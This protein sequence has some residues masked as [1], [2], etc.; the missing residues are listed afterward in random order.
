LGGFLGELP[1]SSADI[2]PL[3]G[4]PATLRSLAN[5]LDGP[6][7]GDLEFAWQAC[8]QLQ[9][10]QSATSCDGQWFD[11]FR[12]K[13]ERNPKPEDIDQVRQVMFEAAR[14][15]R[16]LAWRLEEAQRKLEW[17]RRRIDA[18]EVPSDLLLDPD[19]EAQLRSIGSQADSVHEDASTFVADAAN[20]LGAL[21]H[22]TLY[23]EPPTLADRITGGIGDLAGDVVGGGRWYWDNVGS[24]LWLGFGESSWQ[25][26]TS[27]YDF[28]KSYAS[29]IWG[30]VVAN[31]LVQK[32]WAPA[33][34]TLGDVR[35]AAVGAWDL[36]S[37]LAVYLGRDVWW[38][39]LRGGDWSAAEANGGPY[40]ELGKA[41]VD[42]ETLRTNP[43]RWVGHLMPDALLGLGTG[44]I[45]AVA[46]RTAT[47]GARSPRLL[48]L[49]ESLHKVDGT[50]NV[51]APIIGRVAPALGI[52]HIP[53]LGDWVRD[54]LDLGH[55]PDPATAHPPD[56]VARDHH[57]DGG[58]PNPTRDETSSPR[59]TTGD[60]HP[61][62]ADDHG[63]PSS[64]SPDPDSH[65]TTPPADRPSP[66]D[67]TSPDPA[68]GRHPSPDPGDQT[69]GH[70]TT[71]GDRVPGDSGSPGDR[72]PGDPGSPGD[73]TP[74]TPGS[75]GDRVP[76]DPGTPGDTVPG[77]G[78]PDGTGT[79]APGRSGTS[80]PSP[81]GTPT[82]HETPLPADPVSHDPV[83][84]RPHDPH[85]SRHM[86]QVARS[87]GGVTDAG[88]HHG[89]TG[90]THPS[91]PGRTHHPDADPGTAAHPGRPTPSHD[92]HDRHGTGLSA[93]DV[94]RLGDPATRAR[95]VHSTPI[96]VEADEAAGAVVAANNLQ[97]TSA[98][99]QH[100]TRR[101]SPVQRPRASN[102]D[103]DPPTEPHERTGPTDPPP[104]STSPDDEAS[105]ASHDD[106]GSGDGTSRFD[107]LLNERTSRRGGDDG[108][109]GGS[110]D[111]P[112]R[113]DDLLN[114][115]ITP[116]GKDRV[117]DEP[118]EEGEAGHPD[119][120]VEAGPEDVA[121]ADEDH[122]REREWWEQPGALTGDADTS[123]GANVD[124]DATDVPDGDGSHERWSRLLD[125]DGHS[126]R[127]AT[128]GADV[129][130]DATDVPDGDGS[131]ER[132]SR[133]LDEDGHSD[134]PDVEGD[135]DGDP[136][137]AVP[138]KGGGD[139]HSDSGG[140]AHEHDVAEPPRRAGDV[141]HPRAGRSSHNGPGRAAPP[142]GR[143][144]GGGDE[145]RLD[146]DDYDDLGVVDHGVYARL[147]RE[148]PAGWNELFRRAP[149][150]VDR[151]TAA[152]IDHQRSITGQDRDVLRA[153]LR[154]M[155]PD[156]AARA[157]PSDLVDDL[158][159][160]RGADEGG[161]DHDLRAAL[162]SAD[163]IREARQRYLHPLPASTPQGRADDLPPQDLLQLVTHYSSLS[164]EDNRRVQEWILDSLDGRQTLSPEELWER[165]SFL[166]GMD[167]R[168]WGD[169]VDHRNYGRLQDLLHGPCRRAT[170]TDRTQPQD[171]DVVR[172][173]SP[174]VAE[175]GQAP[176]VHDRPRDELPLEPEFQPDAVRPRPANDDAGRTEGGD[177][178][179]ESDDDG[180]GGARS[181][182]DRPTPGHDSDSRG[183]GPDQDPAPPAP[184]R[185]QT[186]PST[187]DADG[188][189]PTHPGRTDGAG[190]SPLETF[191]DRFVDHPADP[192]E[193]L[194]KEGMSWPPRDGDGLYEVPDP[195][196][197]LVKVPRELGPMPPLPASSRGPLVP[198]IEGLEDSLSGDP[199]LDRLRDVNL[200]GG[201]DNCIKTAV[202][203]DMRLAGRGHYIANPRHLNL[204]GQSSGVH[205]FDPDDDRMVSPYLERLYGT[206]FRQMRVLPDVAKSL[207]HDGA[208]GIVNVVRRGR[209]GD[210]TSHALNA[211]RR[212]GQVHFVDG[213]VPGGADVTAEV[214]SA[215]QKGN[216]LR[217]DLLRTDDLHA[218]PDFTIPR[219]GGDGIDAGPSDTV[220]NPGGP[221]STGSVPEGDGH[222]R[223]DDDLRPARRAAEEPV[224]STDAAGDGGSDVGG[225]RPPADSPDDPGDEFSDGAGAH[226]DD[227]GA[228]SGAD[229]DPTA[230]ERSPGDFQR[231][232]LSLPDDL[233]SL[234][235]DEVVDLLRRSPSDWY[236]LTDHTRRRLF[237][238]LFE[239]ADGFGD[240]DL[241]LFG[242]RWSRL[243]PEDF[244][245]ALPL[246]LE[247]DRLGELGSAL[248]RG[249][250][251][252]I[253][254]NDLRSA[255]SLDGYRPGRSAPAHPPLVDSSGQRLSYD[256]LTA[257]YRDFPEL[258][259]TLP[260]GARGYAE[261]IA[262]RSADCD[263]PRDELEAATNRLR[264]LGGEP[265]RPE[266]TAERARQRA[267]A[268]DALRRLNAAT[269][270]YC[271]SI[272]AGED[273]LRDL[274][275]VSDI[276][277][278]N[279]R[280]AL[281]RAHHWRGDEGQVWDRV[282]ASNLPADLD[283]IPHDRFVAFV[284]GRDLDL[285]SD[286]D[287]AHLASEVGMRLEMGELEPADMDVLRPVFGRLGPLPTREDLVRSMVGFGELRPDT[288][289]ELHRYIRSAYPDPID[290]PGTHD[291]D[292][293]PDEHPD[294]RPDD[295]GS[296]D[297]GEEH[298]GPRTAGT[299]DPPA[300]RDVSDP[301]PGA[302]ALPPDPRP[303]P[304]SVT[305]GGREAHYVGRLSNGDRL[306]DEE[307]GGWLASLPHQLSDTQLWRL[308]DQL[309][310]YLDRFDDEAFDFLERKFR[311]AGPQRV[312]QVVDTLPHPEYSAIA[313]MVDYLDD[314]PLLTRDEL[315]DLHQ[316]CRDLGRRRALGLTDDSRNPRAGDSD[317]GPDGSGDDG[318]GDHRPGPDDGT[319]PRD[320][321]D[322]GGINPV[323]GGGA[324]VDAPAERRHV[325]DGGASS[326]PRRR[327][328]E[329]PPGHRDPESEQRAEGRRPSGRRRSVVR[330]RRVAA[331][332]PRSDGSSGRLG[333]VRNA[334]GEGPGRHGDAVG[335]DGR[336]G[337][338][339][340][341][342]TR[343]VAGTAGRPLGTTPGSPPGR[344]GHGGSDGGE[345]PPRSARPG[346]ADGD[347][348]DDDRRGDA[349][350]S[351]DPGRSEPSAEPATSGVGRERPIIPEG[352]REPHDP[353]WKGGPAGIGRGRPFAAP[354]RRTPG[355]RHSPG[356]RPA[357][358]ASPGARSP[359]EAPGD[360][361]TS[362]GGPGSL[363]GARSRGTTPSEGVGIG[364]PLL[365]PGGSQRPGAP[366]Y[367]GP[368]D[369]GSTGRASAGR[370]DEPGPPHGRSDGVPPATRAEHVRPEDQSGRR[371]RPDPDSDHLPPA[372]RSGPRQF[373]EPAAGDAYGR[374]VWGD[375]VESASPAQR[376]AAITWRNDGQAVNRYLRTGEHGNDHLD[377]T[378]RH[379]DALLDEHPTPEDLR[380]TSSIE[381]ADM[382][383]ARGPFKLAA[384][385]RRVGETLH[386]PDYRSTVPWEPVMFDQNRDGILHLLVPEGTPAVY[387]GPVQP[388]DP[389]A[390]LLLGR[391]LDVEIVRVNRHDGRFHVY[392][393][394]VPR[395]GD[396]SPSHDDLGA[397]DRT[398]S[399]GDDDLGP[400]DDRGAG[401]PA[402]PGPAGPDDAGHGAE[403]DLPAEHRQADGRGGPAPDGDVDRPPADL[404]PT[405]RRL[406]REEGER[407]AREVWGSVADEAE[408]RL[409]AILRDWPTYAPHVNAYL[410]DLRIVRFP[411]FDTLANRFERAARLK[412]TP[413]AIHVT[414]TIEA[415]DTFGGAQSPGELVAGTRRRLVGF[416]PVVPWEADAGDLH[417]DVPA[418]TPVAY[419]GGRL[420]L[421]QG[422]EVDIHEVRVVAGRRHLHGRVVP[423]DD[424][425]PGDA[426]DGAELPDAG[427]HDGDG[428]GA[429]GEP[430]RAHGNGRV[431]RIPPFDRARVVRSPA[432]AGSRRPTGDG[433]PQRSRR[434]GTPANRDDRHGGAHPPRRDNRPGRSPADDRPGRGPRRL[435]DGTVGRRHPSEPVDAAVSRSSDP[436]GAHRPHDVAA[437]RR[438]QAHADITAGADGGRLVDPRN[439][440]AGQPPGEPRPRPV[441]DGPDSQP[442]STAEGRAPV[443]GD[444]SSGPHPVGPVDVPGSAGDPADRGP[445]LVELLRTRAEQINHDAELAG[446]RPPTVASV[447]YDHVT[448]DLHYGVNNSTRQSDEGLSTHHGPPMILHP[449][450]VDRL[451]A[452]SLEAWPPG[453][454]AEVHA[455]NTAMY[456]A[457][458]PEH[459]E[460][461]PPRPVTLDRFSYA[462]VKT[463]TG[464]V[465][466]SCRNCQAILDG[467]EEIL[468]PGQLGERI[469]RAHAR[470]GS[471]SSLRSAGPDAATRVADGERL[472]WPSGPRPRRTARPAARAAGGP[473]GRAAPSAAPPSVASDSTPLAPEIGPDEPI[474]AGG[475]DEPGDRGEH[476]SPDPGARDREGPGDD[477]GGGDGDGG[478][479]SGS[480]G[481]GTDGGDGDDHGDGT[482]P[483]GPGDPADGGP[484]PGG[485]DIP[486]ALHAGQQVDPEAYGRW[487][488]TLPD[489]PGPTQLAALLHHLPSRVEMLE[490]EVVRRIRDIGGTVERRRLHAMA[491]AVR[492]RGAF[493][494]RPDAS[495]LG[496]GRWGTGPRRPT[497]VLPEDFE[498]RTPAETLEHL[499][500]LDFDQVPADDLL[501]I[502]RKW[503]GWRDEGLT[504]HFAEVG[505]LDRLVHARNRLPVE[506][507]GTEA[508]F[509]NVLEGRWP[510]RTLGIQPTT[511]VEDVV[512]GAAELRAIPTDDRNVPYELRTPT[513]AERA[514]ILPHDIPP[515]PLNEMSDGERARFL[516]EVA[517]SYRRMPGELREHVLNH[518]RKVSVPL[519]ERGRDHSHSVLARDWAYVIPEDVALR[520]TQVENVTEALGDSGL[521]DEG[522]L[523]HFRKA[524]KARRR[525]MARVRQGVQAAQRRPL[526]DDGSVIGDGDGGDASDGDGDDGGD[527]GDGDGNGG[528]DGD[529][530]TGTAGDPARPGAPVRPGDTGG[531]AR[532]DER[533]GDGDT[534]PRSDAPEPSAPES[535]RDPLP[536][537]PSRP[538]VVELSYR[539]SPR[540]FA[541]YLCDDG[542]LWDDIDVDELRRLWP[543]LVRYQDAFGPGDVAVL[544]ERWAR[545]DGE[546][547]ATLPDEVIDDPATMGALGAA[548]P[549]AEE[550]RV[551]VRIHRAATAELAKAE[552]LIVRTLPPDS[553]PDARQAIV[554]EAREQARAYAERLT[555]A[556]TECIRQR[557]EL[558]RLLG[559]RP[560]DL[561]TPEGQ[562]HRLRVE[563]EMDAVLEALDDAHTAYR[564]ADAELADDTRGRRPPGLTALRDDLDRVSHDLF[565][566]TAQ[567][568]D[569]ETLSAHDLVRYLREL[570]ARRRRLTTRVFE[571]LR[572]RL[573]SVPDPGRRIANGLVDHGVPPGERA[574][575][576]AALSEL[577]PDADRAA[578][579]LGSQIR[580][581][582]YL[583]GPFDPF[584]TGRQGGL[585]PARY[586]RGGLRVADEL[587]WRIG[588]RRVN[589]GRDDQAWRENLQDV[590]GLLWENWGSLGESELERL[591]E[592]FATCRRE[593]ICTREE[594]DE[595]LE[596]SRPHSAVV[597]THLGLR[598]TFRERQ[599]A[600]RDGVQRLFPVE[601]AFHRML[602]EAFDQDVAEILWDIQPNRGM[603][604]RTLVYRYSRLSPGQRE[605]LLRAVARGL[606]HEASNELIC[607]RLRRGLRAVDREQLEGT[608]P[609]LSASEQLT[610]FRLGIPTA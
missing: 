495:W 365:R 387:F 540:D 219:R 312:Q 404:P 481:D 143:P 125:E 130:G 37:G 369:D 590:V 505:D 386:M 451:P 574:A 160:G 210:V 509:R 226:H 496:D 570:Q 482:P 46:S 262:A 272:L 408:P 206:R 54:K 9:T 483:A 473:G 309:P 328:N 258:V 596:A 127:P 450:L 25:M 528:D 479:G 145:P 277:R 357:E 247:V 286:S 439:D 433:A 217:I 236:E 117:P 85:G 222:G 164:P 486:E 449:E 78:Q 79:G 91:H 89:R 423:P 61:D 601:N 443:D 522:E 199:L 198:P 380:V 597:R 44:S 189:G 399:D 133:L 371:Q 478:T 507:Q 235:H 31:G 394:V 173:P 321:P 491:R 579:V 358:D 11:Q 572:D 41:L 508:E 129:D 178:G 158:I 151:F 581:P 379:L 205:S 211:V 139:D 83:S 349:D 441:G 474:L 347:G 137:G 586:Q 106:T 580:A 510:G 270:E 75:P 194:G 362:S 297:A 415:T 587:R 221:E 557:A 366:H 393:R 257:V 396:V 96:P 243:T 49:A 291:T 21:S 284:R 207:P 335:D 90:G 65:T 196:D 541:R 100:A 180:L 368:G 476:D 42:Y 426:G 402:R 60:S 97:V 120:P 66:G 351:G 99:L 345:I 494:Q 240:D 103:A 575:A 360:R 150:T 146:P 550:I 95:E 417:L 154:S 281:S 168:L 15:L 81:D 553:D 516:R 72:V 227:A 367:R 438:A 104:R 477:G 264:E 484:D 444:G 307:F 159:D 324:E 216:L 610:L 306:T 64:T 577:F 385:R 177:R 166:R 213:Q 185:S 488:R 22:K 230:R 314:P 305:V 176:G 458:I 118:A 468:N 165:R 250:D 255:H 599:D 282:P 350:R 406:T 364:A 521:Y 539:L 105:G 17:C 336:D 102:T 119:E 273:Y 500:F 202:V 73:R 5:D 274:T 304:S 283:Q 220:S 514:G 183:A 355:G 543:R 252:D 545:L 373:L 434:T 261:R 204:F 289:E 149:H 529:D 16:M 400:G 56:P 576:A 32:D 504:A 340:V 560:E 447:V 138:A 278:A 412:P 161:L 463:A 228:T 567:F 123:D 171:H 480:D 401:R 332:A 58:A 76:G 527:G 390:E 174:S 237:Q 253:G 298:G 2:W 354:G 318:P 68:P 388:G 287:R 497:S 589:L 84:A 310:D 462:T 141:H 157:L 374:R 50:I 424:G 546:R 608:M 23:V 356:R 13:I 77:H 398:D 209:S 43:S 538:Q 239:H 534:A 167:D 51:A 267:A 254:A 74:G 435:A 471:G 275:G 432:D 459:P 535:V 493:G 323:D 86:E 603:D 416:Q 109:V 513:A 542:D 564:R 288:Q 319:D 214:E 229:H 113:Y 442:G 331:A 552:G 551:A 511:G 377:E 27:A 110:D 231:E 88:T 116:T 469:P 280:S 568:L 311:A 162:P 263:R 384:L 460:R 428:D 155:T 526:Y 554:D 308:L 403:P 333:D 409:E 585:D 547:L 602:A 303:G 208:R 344:D 569:P 242:R 101:P 571:A 440:I 361:G 376:D 98:A 34:E 606:G 265:D 353:L 544:R 320:P 604:D 39:G 470:D 499:R 467:A 487:V 302:S 425:P 326:L 147:V 144:A 148:S 197:P 378:V 111:D 422:L 466:P 62:Q 67:T 536:P 341:D 215:W 456:H 382:F 348:A 190:R 501:R 94:A 414:G 53:S 465:Y 395:R 107:D 268:D 135:G 583:V 427:D 187:A 523:K 170:A 212:Q 492:P 279:V 337:D 322:A 295:A 338:P 10:I 524:V 256:E 30:D 519:S 592:L 269:E 59:H 19:L 179:G 525:R 249:W 225:R 292:P 241:E 248:P 26:T 70:P 38:R 520:P 457:S 28:G 533:S 375:V 6:L 203:S 175:D 3:P 515:H 153:R 346:R 595:W 383:G 156:T 420:H 29:F 558:H 584:G 57:G 512:E 169:L 201:V 181:T 124:G 293:P 498:A 455:M 108:T 407:Y 82:P 271:R 132:W 327:G 186:Q 503:H 372:R 605:E 294:G 329:R 485:D 555:A 464:E 506:E 531:A 363:R 33:G 48:R 246:E 244:D 69:P 45:G 566:R 152:L 594:L 14:I 126:D 549:A 122:L 87:H 20:E 191:A 224:P 55:R 232:L 405:G 518:F 315:R 339:P 370:P 588:A 445:D 563:R 325:A 419:S 36:G 63:R 454:C 532:G 413:H 410:R 389:G 234:P 391:G 556:S 472:P 40:A 313:H 18:L 431:D 598:T 392:G 136:G 565:V 561:T 397:G 128:G 299:P 452:E 7:V 80:S 301:D 71:P 260:A 142:D 184:R 421:V 317:R 4:S 218:R 1:R 502:V 35:T 418:G 52:T 195:E 300:D 276:V 607:Q 537:E 316:R 461:R 188:P 134:R 93:R 352:A 193:V 530:D 238:A 593:G 131:H 121:G 233:G 578:D 24:Q 489:D 429:A 115:S 411:L 266:V 296:D 437:L 8:K 342:E 285:M 172:S 446:E 290:Q 12:T 359:V 163:E 448:G 600:V 573:T 114:Q 343:P 490:P 47:V 112:G 582:L 330:S 559:E 591:R 562:A 192:E 140:S 251:R 609:R 548:L 430:P 334:I 453:N 517:R 92:Q 223:H 200:Y 436:A 475:H 245:Q 182:D 381:V 259:R